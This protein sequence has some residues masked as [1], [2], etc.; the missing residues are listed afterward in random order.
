M[1]R[2]AVERWFARA[3]AAAQGRPDQRPQDHLDRRAAAALL[4]RRL[5]FA[6]ALAV[7]G[8]RACDEQLRD[9]LVLRAE[10][11]VHRRQVDIGLRDDV[12]Q[13]H[14]AEA[15][16]GIEPFGGGENGRPRMIAGH[17]SPRGG[18]LQF[19]QLYETIV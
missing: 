11:I 8:D 4:L 7:G 1:K 14:V 12:A 6:Q 13:R 5:Q 2:A 16:I 9:Q 19:K 3:E 18:E 17:G 10:M 15:A